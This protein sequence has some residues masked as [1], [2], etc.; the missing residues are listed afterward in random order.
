M[1]LNYQKDP[2]A[3]YPTLATGLDGIDSVVR[4]WSNGTEEVKNLL[5][6]ECTVIYECSYCRSLFR[7]IINFLSHKRTICRS[8]QTSIRMETELAKQVNDALLGGEKDTETD[9]G[10]AE[11]SAYNKSKKNPASLRRV[12]LT[13]ALGKHIHTYNVPLEHTKQ[14]IEVQTL[15]KISRSVPVTSIVNGRQIVE[16][17]PK[18]LAIKERLP[19]DRT[20]LV[21]P[22]DHSIR[23]GDM[24]L[25]KRRG[26]DAEVDSREI[27]QQDIEIIEKIP[28]QLHDVVDFQA[29]RCVAPKCWGIQPF[30]SVS[31]LAHHLAIHH[32]D[33]Q[34]K[35]SCFICGTQ[36]SSIRILQKHFKSTHINV[37]KEH[38]EQRKI[39]ADIDPKGESQRSG[40]KAQ[41]GSKASPSE[42]RSRYRS[43]SPSS[44]SED[45]DSVKTEDRSVT[46]TVPPK[47][48]SNPKAAEKAKVQENKEAA[49]SQQ[50]HKSTSQPTLNA[51][52]SR[53]KTLISVEQLKK[54]NDEIA[55]AKKSG[56][57]NKDKNKQETPVIEPFFDSAETIKDGI[58]SFDEARKIDELLSSNR[59]SHSKGK[60][61]TPENKASN[62]TSPDLDM[63][64]LQ[65]YPP[66]S[67]ASA[68]GHGDDEEENGTPSRPP[69]LTMESDPLYDILAMRR[70]TSRNRKPTKR[71]YNEEF[72]AGP[73]VNV[74]GN[75]QISREESPQK[76]QKKARVSGE[77]RLTNSNKPPPLK[78]MESPVKQPPEETD[79]SSRSST[80]QEQTKPTE[81]HSEEPNE[82]TESPTDSLESRKEA[83]DSA[84]SQ[85]HMSPRREESTVSSNSMQIQV[86]RSRSVPA[87]LMSPK[88]N[89]ESEKSALLSPSRHSMEPAGV[90]SAESQETE[91]NESQPS[92]SQTE[93]S[94]SQQSIEQIKDFV[95]PLASTSKEVQLPSVLTDRYRE[96][97]A[98]YTPRARKMKAGD[99][100]KKSDAGVPGGSSRRKQNLCALKATEPE[101]N[102]EIKER[103]LPQKPEDLSTLPVFLTEV[104]RDIFFAPLR[105]LFSGNE[106]EGRCQCSE[107]GEFFRSIK[108]GRRHMVGHIRV[109]RIR[110]SLCDAGAF[111]CSDMRIHLMFRHCEK[112]HL[113]PP[114]FVKPISIP[115]PCMDKKK[116]DALT[117][118]VDPWHPGRVMY[119][120]GKIVSWA[121]PKPY[122]PDAKI[123]D[124]ILGRARPLALNRSPLKR[125]SSANS[126]VPS[127]SSSMHRPPISMGRQLVAAEKPLMLTAKPAPAAVPPEPKPA[128]EAPSESES[129]PLPVK[130]A[131]NDASNP[132]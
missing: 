69:T 112:L 14:T 76:K 43:L 111:F 40:R 130:D 55:E 99:E 118:L 47:R 123:E 18:N 34:G 90:V 82:G 27:S 107:C 120:S 59:S 5:K 79:D 94:S 29:L 71:Y 25:R 75:G 96:H 115:G 36:F 20:V 114:D 19:D 86:E 101:S 98:F 41:R 42:S 89:G 92:L 127:T 7:S 85:P 8:L 68:N 56:K 93:T 4:F 73:Q 58:I 50:I 77:R 44:P 16:D 23:Y 15:P 121:N 131:T 57:A 10:S 52:R 103:E 48:A 122:Y 110:C 104:Q 91:Q 17:I 49:K 81:T 28:S 1:S 37:L 62:E 83:I 3:Q 22:R 2:T 72:V 87:E 11:S 74:N 108:D 30:I 35:L 38:E 33:T 60:E 67:D 31:V 116:A 132:E 109:M 53:R 70:Q 9:A 80:H 32:Q 84:L 21:M 95:V 26:A 63:A 78:K 13:S 105:P 66:S 39:L 61:S 100:E 64:V 54:L 24:Q 124:R 45:G 106:T 6:N 117:Q 12:N 125:P 126:Q 113:A 102:N 129:P 51:N 128:L 65:R 88:P 97:L 119:T 46:P